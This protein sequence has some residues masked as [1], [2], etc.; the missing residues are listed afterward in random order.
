MS[1][2]ESSSSF[3]HEFRKGDPCSLQTTKTGV[4]ASRCC[5]V[6][7]RYFPPGG[8]PVAH[9][10]AGGGRSQARGLDRSNGSG[11]FIWGGAHIRL[12][13]R[14]TPRRSKPSVPYVGRGFPEQM[15]SRKGR[16]G[17]NFK[18]KAGL[19]H[20]CARQAAPWKSYTTG[21][22]AEQIYRKGVTKRQ[23]EHPIIIIP[24]TTLFHRTLASSKFSASFTL[25]F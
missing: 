23:P 19:M 16:C 2:S 3:D 6:Q 14:N 15:E 1:G 24:F 25:L 12:V 20:N 21:K 18:P 7:R 22:T 5:S 9:A 11:T 10:D 13:A 4:A 8:A 17:F